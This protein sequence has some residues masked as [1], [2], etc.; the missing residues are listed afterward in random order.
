MPEYESLKEVLGWNDKKGPFPIEKSLDQII[1]TVKDTGS[2]HTVIIN[3][4]TGSGKTIAL[5]WHIYNNRKYIFGKS[6]KIRV[7]IA[8]PTI[9]SISKI[10]GRLSEGLEGEV[11]FHAGGTGN[12]TPTSKGLIY[13][14]SQHI[15]NKI[16]KLLAAEKPMTDYADVIVLDEYHTQQ[17]EL[18]EIYHMWA[19]QPAER[20]PVM[21]KMSAT[22]LSNDP[23]DRIISLKPQ[24]SSY[25]ITINYLKKKQGQDPTPKNIDEAVKLCAT[26]CYSIY[27]AAADNLGNLLCFLPRV[28][29]VMRAHSLFLAK[30]KGAK[31]N[32]IVAFSAMHPDDRV[33][34]ERVRKDS[35]TVIFCTNLLESSVTVPGTK[36]I[37]DSMYENH[38]VY[39]E[40]GGITSEVRLITKA[41]AIQRAG[42]TGRVSSGAVLRLIS[43][44]KYKKLA[45]R[46]SARITGIDAKIPILRLMYAKVDPQGMFREAGDMDNFRNKFRKLTLDDAIRTSGSDPIFVNESDPE[47]RSY[48]ITE[49]GIFCAKL[50]ADF[51]EGV[52]LY[53]AVSSLKL[54]SISKKG[55]ITKKKNVYAALVA[56]SVYSLSNFMLKKGVTVPEDYDTADVCIDEFIHAHDKL[57][58]DLD[59]ASYVKSDGPLYLMEDSLFELFGTFQRVRRNF[60]VDQYYIRPQSRK[61][62]RAILQLFSSECLYLVQNQ[63]RD[64]DVNTLTIRL[65]IASKDVKTIDHP[66]EG[67]LAI[68]K[69]QV[70][71]KGLLFK[72]EKYK[73][74][75][76]YKFTLKYERRSGK[77]GDYNFHKYTNLQGHF[78]KETDDLSELMINEHR[79]N[80]PNFTG[81]YDEDVMYNARF[82]IVY[83]MKLLDIEIGDSISDGIAAPIASSSNRPV[84]M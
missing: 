9:V 31:V 74:A 82:R 78:P 1:E 68:V 66:T 16:M 19:A 22:G 71:G 29:D 25:K 38:V 42:R 15:S 67:H 55:V 18:M 35:G 76:V 6:R 48:T 53:N 81:T 4:P 70:D 64:K 63:H 51:R 7:V 49:L 73:E 52:S 46:D 43:E 13:A 5:P 32:T 50:G 62:I 69:G 30:F 58:I 41:S 75:F 8:M 57:G 84:K 72:S 33:K 45:D 17:P 3:S 60:P 65:P 28:S 47:G 24:K 36:Y 61:F 79:R 23:E 56:L 39:N 10:Y 21:I 12:Y 40:K 59:V 2:E 11:F 37:V 83:D 27:K 34:L 44:E 77:H 20:R 26:N 80:T 14:T 54:D